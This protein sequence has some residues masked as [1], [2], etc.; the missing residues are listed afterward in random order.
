MNNFNPTSRLP[1]LKSHPSISKLTEA[2]ELLS[3]IYAPSLK[4]QFSSRS[5]SS[6]EPSS[7]NQRLPSDD[8]DLSEEDL[9]QI[10]RADETERRFAKNWLTQMIG[11]GLDWI[12]E[13][14]EK[15]EESLKDESSRP[16]AISRDQKMWDVS[17]LIDLAGN[18]L[19]SE[20]KVEGEWGQ[21]DEREESFLLCLL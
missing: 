8:L 3:K 4:F 6:D 7:N 5:D 1:R 16:S 17:S 14:A 19:A 10:V 15:D 2:L 9:I 12:Q 18:I 11:S 21:N 13:E 20:A